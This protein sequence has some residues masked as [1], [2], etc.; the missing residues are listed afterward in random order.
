MFV[1]ITVDSRDLVSVRSALISAGI[2][3][4]KGTPRGESETIIECKTVGPQSEWLK[5]CPGVISI[6]EALEVKND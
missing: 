3:C 1:M 5:T 4:D 6:E 2:E